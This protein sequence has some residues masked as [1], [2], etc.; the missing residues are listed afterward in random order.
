MENNTKNKV[1]NYSLKIKYDANSKEK[2]LKLL[3]EYKIDAEELNLKYAKSW[4]IVKN[5]ISVETFSDL[6]K[7]LLGVDEKIVV[8]KVKQ[9]S[10]NKKQGGELE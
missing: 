10:I 7:K 9:Y 4:L 8:E 1:E 5:K 6:E 2:I 3:A